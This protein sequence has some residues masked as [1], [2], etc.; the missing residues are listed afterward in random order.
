[1]LKL[2]IVTPEKRVLDAE[3]DSVT[4]PTSSGEAGIL[5]NHAPLI[6]ALKPGV[7]TYAGKN[8]SGKLAVSGGFVEVSN[9]NVSVLVDSAE[10]PDEID[11]EAAKS[12]RETAEKALAAAG[13][14][15]AE[16]NEATRDALDHAQTRIQLAAAK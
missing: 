11:V 6:S 4:V 9:D 12:A 15:P 14:A 1:M 5:S 3:V 13:Q 7:L 2:E 8:E 10:T 16:E